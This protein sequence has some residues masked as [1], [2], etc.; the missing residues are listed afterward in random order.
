[1]AGSGMD[2]V[3][4]HCREL[5]GQATADPL[6]SAPAFGRVV[7]GMHRLRAAGLRGARDLSVRCVEGSSAD[8]SNNRHGLSLT[9]KDRSAAV[10]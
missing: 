8:Q 5:S 6:A 7:D 4:C 2:G 1:M 3:A 9:L 10:S